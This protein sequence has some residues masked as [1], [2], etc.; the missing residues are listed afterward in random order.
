MPGPKACARCAIRMLNAAAPSLQDDPTA[1]VLTRTV[2]DIGGTASMRAV[3][4][5]PS[6]RSVPSH[7]SSPRRVEDQVGDERGPAGLVRRSQAG[8]VVAVEVLVEEE[9]VLPRG[10]ALQALGAAV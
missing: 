7:P 5:H 9:V 4:R 10:V 2:L 3:G 1:G 8:A 6:G